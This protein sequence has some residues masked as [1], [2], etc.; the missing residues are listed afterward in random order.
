MCLKNNRHH[1]VDRSDLLVTPRIYR[2]VVSQLVGD[3]VSRESSV[4]GTTA[5]SHT[6]SS[7]NVR[8]DDGKKAKLWESD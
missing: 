5:W 2:Y 7:T 8:N 1:K 3:P 4:M 6:N